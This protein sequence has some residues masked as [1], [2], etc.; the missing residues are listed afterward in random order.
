MFG[1]IQKVQQY[2]AW[3]NLQK[4]VWIL[5]QEIGETLFYI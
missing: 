4:D 1:G 5:K 2:V 3:H